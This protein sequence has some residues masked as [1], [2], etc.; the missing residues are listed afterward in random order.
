AGCTKLNRPRVPTIYPPVAEAYFLA[1]QV[2]APA[3]NSTTPIQTAAV[4]CALLTTLVL[5]YG[6]RMLGRNTRLAALWAWCPMIA[7]EAG[8]SA[9]VDVLAVLFTA[10]ALLVLARAETEGRTMLGGVLLGL[11]VATKVTPLLVVPAILRR[12]WWLLMTASAGAAIGLVYAPHAMAVG[13]KIIGFLP[14]YLKQ[15]GYSTGSGFNLIDLVVHGKL[16][17]VAAAIVLG[18]IVLAVLR[19]SDPGQP[20]RGAVVMTGSALAVA[21]PHYQWY[22]VLLVMLVALDGRAEWL[23]LAAA[24]YLP[25]EPDMGS[26][27]IPKPWPAVVAYGTGALIA[28]SGMVI[29]YRNARRAA[30]AV[31]SPAPA[32]ETAALPAFDPASADVHAA[33]AEADAAPGVTVISQ[34]VTVIPGKPHETAGADAPGSAGA[35]DDTREVRV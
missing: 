31:A 24:G 19:F 3:D 35:P 22:A 4:V 20:W 16:A 15:Q 8:N 5:L 9:H 12:R 1:V 25:A 30:P 29:R 17:I 23:A 10:V 2:G 6:L 18:L 34:N 28:Y 14:G 32:A 26:L 27:T 21:T 11:A 7:L 13:S 33:S